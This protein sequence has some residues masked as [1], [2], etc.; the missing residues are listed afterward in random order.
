M[1]IRHFKQRKFRP[2]QLW[3]SKPVLR[4]FRSGGN[5]SPSSDSSLSHGSVPSFLLLTFEN[6]GRL[7]PVGTGRS[8]TS[9]PTCPFPGLVAK[10]SSD[11]FGETVGQNTN[12]Y[13]WKCSGGGWL[14]EMMITHKRDELRAASP[15]M[16]A[17]SSPERGLASRGWEPRFPTDGDGLITSVS[18][19]NGGNGRQ[20]NGEPSSR[21]D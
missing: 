21:G 18:M 11:C 3:R 1:D 5:F 7:W 9:G 15:E 16:F 6:D 13:L 8:E 14:G 19:R 20:R 12:S 17:P 10:V 4:W 2:T